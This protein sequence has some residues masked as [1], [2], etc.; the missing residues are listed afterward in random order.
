MNPQTLVEVST[1]ADGPES[2]LTTYT[3]PILLARGVIWSIYD[4]IGKIILF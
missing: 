1:G 2:V 4:H 3:G